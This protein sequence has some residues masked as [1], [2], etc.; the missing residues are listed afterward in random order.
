M[1]E[2]GNDQIGGAVV[3]IDQTLM[4]LCF[5]FGGVGLLDGNGVQLLRDSLQGGWKMALHFGESASMFVLDLHQ[6]VEQQCR[7]RFA[8]RP[9]HILA[10]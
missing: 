10:D 2:C 7:E 6:F 1:I 5:T 3:G 4:E 8:F 9:A